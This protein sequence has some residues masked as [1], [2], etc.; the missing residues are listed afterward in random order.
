MFHDIRVVFFFEKNPDRRNLPKNKKYILI[1]AIY[2]L[3]PPKYN[4]RL[5][6]IL[7]KRYRSC[8]RR[9]INI[10]THSRSI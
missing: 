4:V 6:K 10:P 7:T 9:Q 2:E 3:A 5:N 1:I 8:R